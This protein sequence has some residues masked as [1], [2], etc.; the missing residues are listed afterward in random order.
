MV[1]KKTRAALLSKRRYDNLP[2][3]K[4][5]KER[6]KRAEH[7]RRWR[8]K[9]KDEMKEMERKFEEMERKLDSSITERNRSILYTL[10]GIGCH[11]NHCRLRQHIGNHKSSE[12]CSKR[13]KQIPTLSC[14]IPLQEMARIDVAIASHLLT[15]S[16]DKITYH[17]KSVVSVDVLYGEA[18][19]FYDN[20]VHRGGDTDT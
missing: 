5:R 10:P 2:A 6:E 7:A 14:I 13:L 12:D 9:K 4:L 19:L 15:K 20:F 16:N 8:Q 1:M 3:D 18:I 17:R 11:R